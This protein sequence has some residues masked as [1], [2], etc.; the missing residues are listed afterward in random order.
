ME[1]SMRSKHRHRPIVLFLI[2]SAMLMLGAAQVVAAEGAAPLV[3]QPL[4]EEALKN[5]H[6]VWVSEAKWRA[7]SARSKQ[8]GSLPDP[9]IMLGYHNEGWSNYSYGKEQ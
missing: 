1:F 9:M 8:A 3:V 4:I 7:S 6:D 2:I 5:N